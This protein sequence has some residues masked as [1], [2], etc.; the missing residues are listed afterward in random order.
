MHCITVPSTTLTT[1]KLP[2]VTIAAVQG[3]RERVYQT[4]HITELFAEITEALH[5]GCLRYCAAVYE[6]RR[7]KSFRTMIQM[8]I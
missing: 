7:G 4:A 5:F 6:E 1:G 2:A 8:M 3:D